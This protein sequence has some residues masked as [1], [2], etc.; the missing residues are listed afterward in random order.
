MSPRNRNWTDQQAE[1]LVGRILQ[2]GVIVSALVVLT[3]GVLFV[4][5]NAYEPAGHHEFRG[6][7][8]PLRNLLEIPREA[9]R[10][11]A[12]GIIQF[13]ILLLILT[14]VARV[15]FTALVFLAR[16]DYVFV[17]VTT[18]VLVLLLFSLLG[19]GLLPG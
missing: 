6:E 14:P 13:G 1:Q 9:A 5:Q 12:R 8:E 4:A 17:A 18:F 15:A 10:L 3:G 19:P 2:I 16:R 11:N 7:P